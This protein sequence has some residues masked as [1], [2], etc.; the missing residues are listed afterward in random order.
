MNEISARVNLSFIRSLVLL[1]RSFTVCSF[2]S[3]SIHSIRVNTPL[4]ILTLRDPPR[5][6]PAHPREHV[7]SAQVAGPQAIRAGFRVEGSGFMV[8]E[9]L[10]LQDSRFGAGRWGGGCGGGF[11]GP[12]SPRTYTRWLPRR[13]NNGCLKTQGSNLHG[14]LESST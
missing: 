4:I 9:G 13:H 11:R 1:F 3:H 12:F 5:P 10:G 14:C 8:Y 2:L 6:G 7:R